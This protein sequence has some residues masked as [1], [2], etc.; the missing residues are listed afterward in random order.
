M[1]RSRVHRRRKHLNPKQ[2]RIYVTR[3]QA[4]P[5]NN[6]PDS[7]GPLFT[8]YIRKLWH[9]NAAR[10]LN[11]PQ[12]LSFRGSLRGGVKVIS[13][14]C[15]YTILPT[16]PWLGPE[17]LSE[18]AVWTWGDQRRKPDS[19][20]A[21]V[22]TKLGRRSQRYSSVKMHANALAP[23]ERSFGLVKFFTGHP[24]VARGK[25]E[26]A[27]LLR[28]QPDYVRQLEE[29]YSD[30]E[31]HSSRTKAHEGVLQRIL[32]VQEVGTRQE[33]EIDGRT[34]IVHVLADTKF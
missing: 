29:L 26:M 31:T 23:K 28:A 21:W 24:R 10:R 8:Q 17:P 3:W 15:K 13:E 32:Q 4:N 25:A 9:F 34:F 22:G 6:S 7:S 30:C 16:G 33:Y 20:S 11:L 14:C 1:W 5:L 2:T 18:E 12:K 19:V 27:K